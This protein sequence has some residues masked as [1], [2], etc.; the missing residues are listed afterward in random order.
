MTTFFEY[1]IAFLILGLV[2]GVIVWLKKMLSPIGSNI[3]RAFF[4]SHLDTM[5]HLWYSIRITKEKTMVDQTQPEIL[6]VQSRNKAIKFDREKK[7]KQ[8][9]SSFE[10]NQSTQNK[11]KDMAKKLI[12]S[13]KTTEEIDKE[14]K[15]VINDFFSGSTPVDTSIKT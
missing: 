3:G 4:L 1:A 5:P 15:K 12:D 7:Q 9:K 10:L 11:I 8:I 2:I 6:E 14:L 13:H